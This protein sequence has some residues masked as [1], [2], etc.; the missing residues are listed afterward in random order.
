MDEQA[1]LPAPPVAIARGPDALL[2]ALSNDLLKVSFKPDAT[3]DSAPPYVDVAS[4]ATGWGLTSAPVAAFYSPGAGY[5]VVEGVGLVKRAAG[6]DGAGHASLDLGVALRGAALMP[7]DILIALA[8]DRAIFV[9]LKL[10]A[11][12]KALSPAEIGLADFVHV[13]A[14][15]LTAEG[16]YVQAYADSAGKVAYGLDL[17]PTTWYSVAVGEPLYA[18][19]VA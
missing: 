1:T 4:V 2:M 18:L 11:I 17:D 7:P 19:S 3:I 5:V 16:R 8:S 9:D 10:M 15:P 12:Y 13:A 14:G 6:A